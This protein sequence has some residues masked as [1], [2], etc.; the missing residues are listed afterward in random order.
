MSSSPLASCV[1]RHEGQ[2]HEL[3]V[4]NHPHRRTLY[5]YVEGLSKKLKD[6]IFTHLLGYDTRWVEY[7]DTTSGGIR[8]TFD[9]SLCATPK[10]QIAEKHLVPA[11]LN[12]FRTMP[13]ED[14]SRHRS[15]V[16]KTSFAPARA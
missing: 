1:L 6:A 7:T 15:G 10:Q 2:D 12:A 13:T 5:V 4:L 11:I 3:K 16:P 14:T 9:G 8:I